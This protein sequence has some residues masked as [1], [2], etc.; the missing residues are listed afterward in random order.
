MYVYIVFVVNFVTCFVHCVVL[1][2]FFFFC[3]LSLTPPWC[4]LRSSLINK[5]LFCSVKK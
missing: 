5:V 3:F 4:G 2:F 1:F